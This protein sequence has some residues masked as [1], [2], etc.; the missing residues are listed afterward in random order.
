[1]LL[2]VVDG[3]LLLAVVLLLSLCCGDGFS[4]SSFRV[5]GADSDATVVQLVFFCLPWQLGALSVN[6]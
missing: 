1:M 6:R 4:D 2:L 5:V 3:V